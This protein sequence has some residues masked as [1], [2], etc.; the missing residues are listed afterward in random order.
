MSSAMSSA[1]SATSAVSDAVKRITNGPLVSVAVYCSASS[2]RRL[3]AQ[4]V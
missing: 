1:M 2:M 3:S 4:S